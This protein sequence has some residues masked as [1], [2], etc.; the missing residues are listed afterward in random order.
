M[1][2]APAVDHIFDSIPRRRLLSAS[3]ADKEMDIGIEA[4]AFSRATAG[5]LDF[6]RFE[7]D[8]RE[9]RTKIDAA[10]QSSSGRQASRGSSDRFI[11]VLAAYEQAAECLAITG[12]PRDS[13]QL[14]AWTRQARGAVTPAFRSL[15]GSSDALFNHFVEVCVVLV[16][17]LEDVGETFHGPEVETLGR[18]VLALA[19]HWIHERESG[20]NATPPAAQA[21][22]PVARSY[23]Q[24]LREIFSLLEDALVA[25]CPTAMA[26]PDTRRIM[27]I[28]A[29]RSLREVLHSLTFS[30]CFDLLA[31]G[32]QDGFMHLIGGRVQ[33]VS[34]AD[35]ELGD[36]LEVNQPNIFMQFMLTI[37]ILHRLEASGLT[38]GRDRLP[39]DRRIQ[40]LYALGHAVE[41]LGNMSNDVATLF[42]ELGE[43]F[44]ANFVLA[45]GLIRNL[46]SPRL[47]QQSFAELEKKVPM[48]KRKIL[49]TGLAQAF[50]DGRAEAEIGAFADA[51]PNLS[52]TKSLLETMHRRDL[53][54]GALRR[55]R[56]S[57]AA[58]QQCFGRDHPLD[59]V[60]DL[61]DLWARQARFLLQYITANGVV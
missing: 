34:V 7:R 18:D 13:A 48:A 58:Y 41:R 6:A 28:Y 52:A 46:L 32:E 26:S 24:A 40:S 47:L 12:S 54:G 43:G 45:D 5:A 10:K 51:Y 59:T 17:V 35:L 3:V 44:V 39:L 23:L 42:R 55:W 38:A 19:E 36:F 16:V 8:R 49:F 60:L 50:F 22:S 25:L 33:W 20:Q 21:S 4:P 31:R 9:L 57:F 29:A 53:I 2:P 61:E 30:R 37:N 56:R 1:S 14:I 27:D 15:P 11:R